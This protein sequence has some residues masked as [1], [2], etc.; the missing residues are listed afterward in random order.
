[1]SLKDLA[2]RVAIA[3][4]T[5]PEVSQRLYL[6][7]GCIINDHSIEAANL[8]G[9][10]VSGLEMAQNSQRLTWSAEEVDEKLNSI[11]TNC[12]NVRQTQIHP[13]LL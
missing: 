1:M 10:A 4:G 9:V 12:F 13:F 2:R 7:V 5:R 3:C 6:S 11:M 8:G